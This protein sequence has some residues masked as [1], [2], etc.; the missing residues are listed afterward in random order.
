L[1]TNTK[2]SKA[3]E[4]RIPIINLHMEEPERDPLDIKILEE[5]RHT[6][7]IRIRE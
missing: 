7:K 6:E 2:E 3:E 1:L 4:T 5:E